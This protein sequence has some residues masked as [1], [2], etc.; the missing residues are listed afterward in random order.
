MVCE[1]YT[2][3]VPLINYS[4]TVLSPMNFQHGQPARNYASDIAERPV[5]EWL[6]L[7]EQAPPS[8]QYDPPEAIREQIKALLRDYHA[9]VV[10]DRKKKAADEAAHEEIR[11]QVSPPYTLE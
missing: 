5:R 1:L 10:F 2:A 11:N 9:K 7:V 3:R 6:A 4:T 8:R